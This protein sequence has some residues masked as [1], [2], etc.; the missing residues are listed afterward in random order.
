M[1]VVCMLARE[2]DSSSL[3]FIGLV[4]FDIVSLQLMYWVSF[5]I[6]P[7]TGDVEVSERGA[8]SAQQQRTDA[9]ACYHRCRLCCRERG[10]GAR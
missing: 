6:N 1:C 5:D 9:G 8:A 10:T 3:L 4:S 7:K 2:T